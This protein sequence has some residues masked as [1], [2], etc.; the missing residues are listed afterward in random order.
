MRI[1]GF[2]FGGIVGAAAA[3]L[4]NRSRRPFTFA[5]AGQAGRTVSSMMDA[6]KSK[7]ID[8]AFAR[9]SESDNGQASSEAEAGQIKQM[10]N[11]EPELKKQS[12][13]VMNAEHEV[14]AQ[15]KQYPE[16]VRYR[17]PGA[18]TNRAGFFYFVF[19]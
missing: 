17:E 11:A 4:F 1:S 18:G 7:L 6:A 12:D 19:F 14:S 13:A 9:K 8:R 10:I 15:H 3:I 2:L 16:S 5:A